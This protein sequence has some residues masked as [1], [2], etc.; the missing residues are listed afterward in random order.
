VYFALGNS[1]LPG[2]EIVTSYPSMLRVVDSPEADLI[3]ELHGACLDA[4]LR[5]DDHQTALDSPLEQ[6]RARPADAA[7]F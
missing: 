2:F 1:T 4:V 3:E 6:R 7:P 5:A